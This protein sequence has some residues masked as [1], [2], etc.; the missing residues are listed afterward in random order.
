MRETANYIQNIYAILFLLRYIAESLTSIFI[1]KKYFLL[2]G[3]IIPILDHITNAAHEFVL[4][5]LT[6]P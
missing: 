5:L 2:T 1:T 3:S 4:S 6:A